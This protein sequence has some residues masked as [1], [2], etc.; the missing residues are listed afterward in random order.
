MDKKTEGE[1]GGVEHKKS[2][3]IRCEMVDSDLKY[4]F[5]HNNPLNTR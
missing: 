4:V 3:A 1:V 5:E 2:Q